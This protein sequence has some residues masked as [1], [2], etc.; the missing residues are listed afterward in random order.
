[1]LII[2]LAL[3]IWSHQ[4]FLSPQLR[5]HDIALS[6]STEKTTGPYHWHM[7]LLASLEVSENFHASSGSS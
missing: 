5:Q 4:R 1:M 6:A 7:I 2:S 3:L